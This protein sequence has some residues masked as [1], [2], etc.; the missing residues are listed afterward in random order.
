MREIRTY[1]KGAPF[2]NAFLRTWVGRDEF[3]GCGRLCL[4]V[5]FRS[6][7]DAV[8]ISEV[9]RNGSVEARTTNAKDGSASLH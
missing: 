3:I 7:M 4:C 8:Q 5:W 2:Y 9:R 1:F 6:V